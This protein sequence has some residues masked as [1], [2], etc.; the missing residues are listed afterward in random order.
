MDE[1]AEIR[2]KALALGHLQ[3]A[4]AETA[5]TQFKSRTSEGSFGD[6]LL[7]K[8]MVTLAQLGDLQSSEEDMGATMMDSGDSIVGATFSDCLVSRKLGQGGMGSVYLA[9]KLGDGEEV[10]IKFLAEEQ[11]SNPTWRARFL[12]EAH[13]LEKISHPNIVGIHSVDGA[14]AQPHIVMEFVDGRPLDEVVEDGTVEAM[15]ATRIAHACALALANAHAAGVIHRDIKPA[16]ILVAHS[17]EVKVLD[18]GLAK[19]VA[20]DD[21]LSMPGQILGTP[22]YM[23]PEQWGDHA[24]DARCDIFSLG[25]TL[26]HLL[27]NALPFPGRKPQAISRKVLKGEFI[28]PTELV[29]GV[30]DDLE[31]V[32]FK[33]MDRERAFRYMNAS[34]LAADLKQVLEDREVDVPRLIE[35]EG[36]DPEV[37]FPL[38][39]GAEFVMGRDEGNE[40]MIADRSVSRQHAKIE[41]GKT[42]FVINDL[43]STYGTFVGGMRIRN[44][45]LKDKDEV[46][47]G[48]VSFLFRDGGLGRVAHTTR[49]IAPD[50]M[51]VRTLPVP[52]VRALTQAGDRRV[53][54]NLLEGLAPNGVADR[55]AL[56]RQS[57]RLRLGG[58]IAEAVGKAMETALNRQ[59]RRIPAQLFSITHENGADDIERWLAWWDQ[60]RPHYP[61]QIAPQH[62]AVP[63]ELQLVRGEPE[64]RTISLDNQTVFKV[65]REVGNAV[66]LNSRSVSRLHATIL[67][68]HERFVLRDEGSRFGTLL[69]G[70][71][72]Q[73][74][75]LRPGD[76]I[77]L[78]KV[79]LVFDVDQPDPSA[80]FAEEEVVRVDPQAFFA[81][82]DLNHPCTAMGL[83]RFLE[84]TSSDGNWV[85]VEATRL[86]TEPG[87]RA[88]FL[89]SVQKAYAAESERALRVLPVILDA[90]LQRDVG[91]WQRLLAEKASDLPVQLF[92]QGWFPAE[93]T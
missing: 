11:A 70:E 88:G 66:Q 43:G 9:T 72:I 30:P 50:R 14:C 55:A 39:P 4:Q 69:N 34:D 65:G 51:R 47:V 3:S 85:D 20:L 62:P 92:P 74:A 54:Q 81:L 1:A 76:R 5:Y 23:A 45:V 89:K 12:R 31:L 18:F 79:E 80:T 91:G 35:L 49:R 73:S 57:L 63:G 42:G 64:P 41:R 24:V 59:R 44:V 56:V 36:P 86:F 22:H 27:T 37:R 16:N 87:K 29:E 48:K 77:V 15:E 68:F 17:G 28:A 67:R 61:P 21:G 40:I 32:I 53:V 13:V 93:R 33:M 84:E 26:Y 6:F 71:R 19:N 38:L 25:A 78:G 58:E 83:L 8:G 60:S 75:F 7:E 2:D 46:K 10:V 52:L 82:A 90:D